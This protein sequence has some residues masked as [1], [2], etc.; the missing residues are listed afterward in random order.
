MTFFDLIFPPLC[1]Y[2]G[3]LLAQ[4]AETCEKCAKLTEIAPHKETLENGTQCIAALKYS[5]VVRKAILDY[6]YHG[7]RQY[8]APFSLTYCRM[9]TEYLSGDTFDLYTSVPMKFD[10]TGRRFD[11]VGLIASKTAKIQRVPYK[12]ILDQT[13]AKQFQHS[14][15]REQRRENAQGLYAVKNA[16][17]IREKKVLIFDDI[18]TTGSTLTACS[19]ALHEAGAK[20][21]VCITLAW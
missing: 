20:R 21:V 1:P 5:D 18:K 6:K 3:E 14:L 17:D 9:I 12:R 15:N 2:C 10:L 7:H 13:R 8:A 19:D 11:H 16:A 4:N